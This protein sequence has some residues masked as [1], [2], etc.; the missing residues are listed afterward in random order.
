MEPDGPGARILLS[1]QCGCTTAENFR[2][3][4]M[5]AAPC[6]ALATMLVSLQIAGCHVSENK[7][8][9]NDNV[10]IST[11]FGSMKVKT[12]DSVD[13]SS[14]G[15]SQ[16]PGAVPVKDDDDKDNNDSADVNLSF[17]DFHLGVKAASFQTGDSQSKVLDF[18]RKDLGTKFGDV[19][20]CK[21]DKPIG[22]PTRTSQ[23]LTCEEH[24]G[25]HVKTETGKHAGVAIFS[26]SD[27][28]GQIELRSGSDTRQHIVSVESKDGGTRIGLVALNLP[29]QL[30]TH[31][32]S[33]TE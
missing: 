7:N 22:T 25:P 14:I 3:F 15:I 11:P 32:K 2:G 17:G 13:L 6:L 1:N 4:A 28:H 16:Y 33:D 27:K 20:E 9:K 31:D 8:G 21:D 12:N 5:T 26:S 18:Y 19:I 30:H 10:D 23:G 24:D 29:S